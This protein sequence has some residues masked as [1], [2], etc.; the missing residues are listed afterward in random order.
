[1][2]N[3]STMPDTTADT[4]DHALQGTH[5]TIDRLADGA[6]PL[7]D[8]LHEGVAV[9]EDA[10]R[11]TRDQLRDQRDAWAQTMRASVR[12]Q[13]LAAV[14]AAFALGAVFARITR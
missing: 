4:L 2:I 5:D 10:L 1:M 12:R 6:A 13:P 8:Q 11:A 14:A 3:P 9:A 7:A